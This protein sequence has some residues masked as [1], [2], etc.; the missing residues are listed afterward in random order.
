MQRA[1]DANVDFVLSAGDFCNDL[2]GSP[3]LYN[4]F[5]GYVTKEGKVL[6][7]Y[8]VYGNHE[9]EFG[10]SMETVTWTLV[11]DEYTDHTVVWGTADGSFRSDIGYY[12]FESQGFR[13]IGLDSEH[14][15][16]PTTG[17]YEHNKSGS[18]G[19]PAGNTK[20]G[21]LGPD[22]LS[23]LEAVLMDAADKKI[24]CIVMAHDGFGPDWCDTSPDAEA[25]RAIYRKA[26]DKTAGTVLMSINGHIHTDH[27]GWM[28]GVFY[29]DTNTVRN[30]WWQQTAVAHYG[31]EHTFLYEEYDNAGNLIDTYE[32]KYNELTMGANTW[33][34]EDAVSCN[35]V[36]SKDGTVTI[37]GVKSDW[38]FGIVPTA[39]TTVDGVEPE[40]TSGTYWD[41]A[42]QGHVL[43]WITEGN[44]KRYACVNSQCTYVAETVQYSGVVLVLA[45]GTVTDPATVQE[46][47]EAAQPGSVIRLNMNNLTLEI[48]E[49]KT[50][51]VDVNGQIVNITGSGTFQG[52]DSTNDD[53]QLSSGK[54]TIANTVTIL[55][56]V[57]IDSNGYRYIA[58]KADDGSYSFHRLEMKLKDVTLRTE[59]AGVFYK[60]LYN[61][62]D[63]LC[64]QVE[65][66][67]VALSVFNMP[68]ADFMTEAQEG[69]NNRYTRITTPLEKGVIATS[70]SVL[71]IMKDSNAN[72]LNY[73]NGN[74]KIYANPY[75]T[76]KGGLTLVTD[77]KNPGKTADDASFDGISHSLF[78]VMRAIDGRYDR[79]TE[80]QQAVIESFYA[81][82][83]NK[84]LQLQL[85]NIK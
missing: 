3:E 31:D 16:N 38:A 53:F 45:N 41:C 68:G 12:Y 43:E 1:D 21:S 5:R 35:V 10:N 78:D 4:T 70:G 81:K 20:V 50:I 28:D 73:I 75:I 48:P 17:K 30:T 23:W 9:L 82:W 58:L 33:F 66:Y 6:P 56:D 57:T 29:L 15:F 25:V 67:G 85:E 27:Q 55:P 59:G 61:C 69:N 11:N 7:A 76:L 62:D 8:N 49:G 72:L 36:V 26:N 71:N 79:Y 51:T 52:I 22:Q 24:P 74:K 19:A 44:E 18:S 39:A 42:R 84:G 32:K 40:I 60:A 63:V 83:K 2:A 46:A 77:N 34:S 37:D 64:G 14:S 65:A 47:I 54:A 13:I 80:E